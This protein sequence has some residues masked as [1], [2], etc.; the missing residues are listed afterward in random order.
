LLDDDRTVDVFE[1]N[2][3]AV[4]PRESDWCIVTR[5]EHRGQRGT[6]MA[7]DQYTDWVVKLPS[8]EI[9]FLKMQELAKTSK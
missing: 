9:L 1:K 4:T 3:I 7:V 8:E 2:L 6:V 5:G